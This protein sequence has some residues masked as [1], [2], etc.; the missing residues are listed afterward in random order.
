MTNINTFFE[1]TNIQ[2]ITNLN[3]KQEKE[4]NDIITFDDLDDFNENFKNLIDIQ[5]QNNYNNNNNNNNNNS[6]CNN[7]N[8]NTNTNSNNKNNNNNNTNNNSIY[9]NTQIS[10]QNIETNKKRNFDKIKNVPILT[11][12]FAYPKSLNSKIDNLFQDL[13]GSSLFGCVIPFQNNNNNNLKDLRERDRD[14]EKNIY[15]DKERD[16]DKFKKAINN[17]KLL[18]QKNNFPKKNEFNTLNNNMTTRRNRNLE[19]E[20]I[21][22]KNDNN[23]SNIL[24]INI[25][26]NIRNNLPRELSNP[27]TREEFGFERNKKRALN[28]SK[29]ICNL[30]SKPNLNIDKT[31]LNEKK[32]RSSNKELKNKNGGLSGTING[33]L[34]SNINI[35]TNG[36]INGNTNK[37]SRYNHLM[38][39]SKTS[40]IDNN[41]SINI[42]NNSMLNKNMKCPNSNLNYNE[43]INN[44][45][46]SQNNTQYSNFVTSSID[47]NLSSTYSNLNFQQQIT[48][49]NFNETNGLNINIIN[50]F[51]YENDHV[52]LK[53]PDKSFF[54]VKE[55]GYKEEMNPKY[56]NSM[57]DFVKIIDN[58]NNSNIGFF[59]LFDGHGGDDAVKYAKENISKNLEKFINERE[60]RYNREECLKKTFLAVDEKLKFY[61]SENSGLTSTVVLIEGKMLYIA[62]VG[63]SGCFLLTKN[64]EFKKIS[65]DHNCLNEKE[66]ERIKNNGGKIINNRVLG[67]LAL[68]RALGDHSLRKYGVIAEPDTNKIQLTN[69]DKYVIIASDGIWDVLKEDDIKNIIKE[70]EK[71]EKICENLIQQAIT[72]GSK[73]NISCIF[74]K[75]N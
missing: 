51:N 21:S 4:V 31:N 71:C 45:L 73:D 69:N 54:S 58:F 24:N 72:K 34:N 26:N 64:K 40:F 19:N 62:N 60:Y 41:A 65:V 35:N 30:I 10:H 75:L 59:G 25:N 57:E 6:N 53:T 74:I 5:K 49:K 32:E 11:K 20:E 8:T 37:N 27:N 48:R 39:K 43:N 9:Q 38:N 36:N 22:N 68:T 50:N 16:I 66:L 28:S 1:N 56:K 15:K 7:T 23:N 46:L 29:E 12:E 13:K 47:P 2:K 67:Q 33:T 44:I 55:Y 70:N 3:N 14:I 61:D 17:T 18:N 52:N 63:D 42:N